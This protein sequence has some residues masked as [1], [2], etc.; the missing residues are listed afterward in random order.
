MKRSALLTEPPPER[1][2]VARSP[3]HWLLAGAAGAALVGMLVLSV[4]LDPDP[5]GVGTHEQLGL[6]PCLS[7]KLWDVPCPGCGVT[8]AATLACQG[9][10]ADS[11]A[12]Q[13]FGLVLVLVAALFVP[14]VA[15]GLLRGRDLGLEL[16]RLRPGLWLLALGVLMAAAWVYKLV[17]LRS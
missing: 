10:F 9:R 17:L 14:W 11:L 5:R 6:Q 15:A 16:P 3:L 4:F 7:L 8:T 1:E 12:T 13:P 2:P